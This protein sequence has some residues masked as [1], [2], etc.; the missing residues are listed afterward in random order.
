MQSL[1]GGP[2]RAGRASRP[3]AA[4]SHHQ[5]NPRR[6][7]AA[8]GCAVLIGFEFARPGHALFDAA[9]WR[10][11]FPTCRCAG[12]IPDDV[13]HRIDHADRTAI[14]DAVP[15]ATDDDTFRRESAIIDAAWMPGNLA[16]LLD[17]APLAEFP[18]FAA[19]PISAR[20]PAT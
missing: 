14:A 3:A 9:Y 8:D 5:G 2:A 16:W 20:A 6:V 13:R 1:G 4:S 11:G 10:M 19:G 17:G 15:A 18:A 7:L 12:A